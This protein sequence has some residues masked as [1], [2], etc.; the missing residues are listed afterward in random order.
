MS[1]GSS[2][3]LANFSKPN[4]CLTRLSWPPDS[5]CLVSVHDQTYRTLTVG[6]EEEA[7]PFCSLGE[8]GQ[9]FWDID[10]K[11]KAYFK[12]KDPLKF[13]FF[14]SQVWGKFL[15]LSFSSRTT[16]PNKKL[17]SLITSK[18]IILS[19]IKPFFVILRSYIA[20]FDN[21]KK[22]SGSSKQ[23]GSGWLELVGHTVRRICEATHTFS[24]TSSNQPGPDCLLAPL[25]FVWS[26]QTY[27]MHMVWV[28]EGV[29]ICSL[30]EHDH[31]FWDSDLKPKA[32]FKSKSLLNF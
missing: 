12:S 26:D 31:S 13:L 23:S 15:A 24:P 14:W 22:K 28:Q 11:P 18:P 10:L 30:C 6:Q 7:V 27:R 2:W 8:H 32:F 5:L 9:C 20:V 4:S 17:F 3:H 25:S 16:K 29:W 19:L 1:E 21:F